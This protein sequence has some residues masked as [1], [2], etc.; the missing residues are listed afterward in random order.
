LQEEALSSKGGPSAMKK[1]ARKRRKGTAFSRGR[2]S[3]RRMEGKKC[4]GNM[5][6]KKFVE[7][8]R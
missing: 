7:E 8:K 4:E 2:L 3:T 1:A 6:E 5:Q